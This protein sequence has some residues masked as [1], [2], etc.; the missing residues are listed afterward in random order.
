MKV[1]YH[2]R[3]I[4]VYS[5]DPAAAPGRIE[6]IYREL[7]GRFDFVEPEP[8]AEADLRLAHTQEH[9][10]SIIRRDSHLYEVAILAAG[11]AIKA[12]ELAMSGQPTFALIRPP[13]HHASSD[14]GWGFCFFNNIQPFAPFFFRSGSHLPKIHSFS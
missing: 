6:A 5:S 7:K 4:E 13:G 9:I 2:P 3:Y 10:D 12:A 8:A 14:S 11:G 1:V